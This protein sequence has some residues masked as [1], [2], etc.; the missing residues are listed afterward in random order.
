MIFT[1]NHHTS[2]CY[3]KFTCRPSYIIALPPGLKNT[4]DNVSILRYAW[5]TNSRSNVD[6]LVYQMALPHTSIKRNANKSTLYACLN[7]HNQSNTA[8]SPHQKAN[9]YTVVQRQNSFFESKPLLCWKNDLA[10]YN[11]RIY[12]LNTL[13]ALHLCWW[14]AKNNKKIAFIG[15]NGDLLNQ[16]SSSCLTS[17]FKS[18]SLTR[19]S[20]PKL[21]SSLNKNR[22]KTLSATGVR[23]KRLY[24]KSSY[25]A[26]LRKG[27]FSRKLFQSYALWLNAF[28]PTSFLSEK[29][30]S[31]KTKFNDKVNNAK[32][33][34]LLPKMIKAYAQCESF[35][36]HSGDAR[37]SNPDQ[38]LKAAS[39]H[40]LCLRKP[41][42]E[43]RLTSNWAQLAHRLGQL[44]L[45]AP[46]TEFDGQFT[47]AK[48]YPELNTKA[49]SDLTFYDPFAKINISKRRF[50]RNP[51][52]AKCMAREQTEIIKFLFS[53]QNQ[54]KLVWF[55]RKQR[56][57]PY[58]QPVEK[59]FRG[60]FVLN[61][62]NKIAFQR[63]N[64]LFR[65][66]KRN[67]KPYNRR[68]KQKIFK[69][70]FYKPY[71]NNML[72][73]IEFYDRAS[74]VI[75]PNLKQ[76]DVLFFIH[77]D[78]T[79]GMVTMAR[80][81][82]IATI[83][84]VCGLKPKNKSRLKQAHLAD[85]VNYPIVGNADNNFF[86]LLLLRTFLRVIYKANAPEFI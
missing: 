62:R 63:H 27:S 16:A 37:L 82:R 61:H 8:Y 19:N 70:N 84:L 80:N 66:Q 33:Y 78:K 77:P 29:Q 42:L 60:R 17:W 43:K 44:G 75:N 5:K 15:V 79:P 21:R 52:H 46:H 39:S 85:G 68:F 24:L 14:A 32:G 86:V 11:L 4:N 10:Y 40:L 6:T 81:L 55:K 76:A 45:K 30:A 56:I 69:K 50:W 59:T 54:N 22:F 34:V 83:G 13:K 74:F 23:G 49:K 3:N 48:V 26:Q 64:V 31:L 1:L 25:A 7:I 20:I 9:H 53:K 51:S 47:P 41:D 65:G 35:F 2:Y 71:Y 73:R 38:A 12:F 57:K 67:F 36:F 72:Q 18:K 58:L 28:K